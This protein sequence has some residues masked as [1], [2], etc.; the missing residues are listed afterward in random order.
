MAPAPSSLVYQMRNSPTHAC[1]SQDIVGQPNFCSCEPSPGARRREAN[2]GKKLP[3]LLLRQLWLSST[4]LC[5]HQDPG[6]GSAGSFALSG[7]DRKWVRAD[8]LGAVGDKLPARNQT[9]FLIKKC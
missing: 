1:Q 7:R 4:W 9:H 2:E 8:C 5:R 3:L 6:G